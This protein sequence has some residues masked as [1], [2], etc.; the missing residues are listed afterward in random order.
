MSADA[1]PPIVLTGASGFVG[2]PLLRRLHARGARVVSV[3]RTRPPSDLDVRFRPWDMEKESFPIELLGPETVLVHLAAA[4]G[5]ADRNTMFRANV[6]GTRR[7]IVAS[8]AA[9]IAHLIQVS[10]VA[11][12]FEDQRWYPYANSK[13]VAEELVR[14][15]GVP[16]TIVRPT[17]VLGEGSAI[18]VGLT[19]LAGSRI[20]VLPGDPRVR[21]Q[22]VDV[23]DV[24]AVLDALAIGPAPS[25]PGETLEIGGAESLT[26]ADLV[27]RI[28]AQ[29]GLPNRPLVGVRVS[30]LRRMLSLAERI[31]PITLPVT[32]GQLAAFVND[33][34][35][36]PPGT[37]RRF[38]PHPRDV[39][40]MLT[41]RKGGA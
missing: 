2:L 4:T 28:R 8:R 25:L 10:S 16:Y 20:P 6:E 40:A 27:S 26:M 18:E 15:G 30:L 19:R 41:R 29:R 9:G 1:L 11:A 35:A 31:S 36:R 33:V 32:S 34:D 23:S 21:T 22:P 12:R 39:D 7:V 13:R 5:R 24:V 37:I 14:V 38:L 3:G 17:M